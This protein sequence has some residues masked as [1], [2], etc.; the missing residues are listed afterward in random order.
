MSNNSELKAYS[1]NGF[2]EPIIAHCFA[3]EELETVYD[4]TSYLF[5]HTTNGE[6]SYCKV[7]I[8]HEQIVSIISVE[9]LVENTVRETLI[10]LG[11]GDDYFGSARMGSV[12][13]LELKRFFENRLLTLLS[14]RRSGD[15]V[16][17]C[18][19]EV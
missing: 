9:I 6:K 15:E 16:D 4:N 5:T 10:R 2:D 7:L 3:V 13:Y 12:F 17:E 8:S 14:K 1:Y 11:I 19:A 18:T